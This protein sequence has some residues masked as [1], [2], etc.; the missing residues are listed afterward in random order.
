VLLAFEAAVL[1]L[2][3]SVPFVAACRVP[4][5]IAEEGPRR[6]RHELWSQGIFAAGLFNEYVRANG[7]PPADLQ[8]FSQWLGQSQPDPFGACPVSGQPYVL[9]RDPQ[10]GEVFLMCPFHHERSEPLRLPF[11]APDPTSGPTPVL[12][13]QPGAVGP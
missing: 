1:L 4:H 6:C 13:T 5:A 9:E 10:T 2:I 3:V 7:H 12:A 8:T 11:P